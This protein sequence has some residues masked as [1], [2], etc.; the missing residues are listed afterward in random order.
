MRFSY[1]FGYAVS[2]KFPFITFRFIQEDTNAA[3]LEV[4][5]IYQKSVTAILDNAQKIYTSKIRL[6]VVGE[7]DTALKGCVQQWT[8]NVQCCG[9]TLEEKP[10]HNALVSST[11]EGHKLEIAGKRHTILINHVKWSKYFLIILVK[12]W[13]YEQK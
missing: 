7:K 6:H 8:N 5:A 4:N 13:P 2:L 11:Q 12:N 1:F 9:A 3:Q 10:V